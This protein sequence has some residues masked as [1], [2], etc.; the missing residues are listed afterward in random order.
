MN[1]KTATFGIEN[2]NRNKNLKL[3]VIEYWPNGQIKKIGDKNYDHK[4]KF[5]TKQRSE[6]LRDLE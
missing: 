4:G 1:G 2:G 3:F 6:H 5:P